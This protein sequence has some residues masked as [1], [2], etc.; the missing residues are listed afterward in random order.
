V[1]TTFVAIRRHR[2]ARV[3]GVLLG[4]EPGLKRKEAL[5]MLFEPALIEKLSEPEVESILNEKIEKT[6]PRQSTRKAKK[7][8]KVKTKKTRVPT[9]QK[10]TKTD[11]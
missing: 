4:R 9:K 6:K 7:S 11:K 1:L 8:T 5:R 2:V 3:I 10:K